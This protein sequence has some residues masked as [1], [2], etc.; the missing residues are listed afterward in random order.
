M[1]K[2]ISTSPLASERHCARPLRLAPVHVLTTRSNCLLSHRRRKTFVA[3]A[4]DAFN[5]SRAHRPCVI[6]ERE[7]L[8]MIAVVRAFI[9]LQCTK[10]ILVKSSTSHRKVLLISATL[11][12]YSLAASTAAINKSCSSFCMIRSFQHS[13]RKLTVIIA[14][15]L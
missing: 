4:F 5:D 15:P 3:L 8:T 6:A 7:A 10:I 14:I 9:C 13:R 11:S 1:W 12:A 2:K